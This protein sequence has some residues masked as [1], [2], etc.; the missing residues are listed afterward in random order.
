MNLKD[1]ILEAITLADAYEKMQIDEYI[2]SKMAKSHRRE[3]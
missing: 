1:R 3:G 2:K